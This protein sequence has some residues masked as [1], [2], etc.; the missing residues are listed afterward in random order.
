MFF[1]IVY[2]VLISFVCATDKK[3]NFLPCAIC[4]THPKC[5]SLLTDMGHYVPHCACMCVSVF[6]DT[7]IMLNNV[8]KF[9]FKP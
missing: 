6:C 5:V 1:N 9:G 7:H 4:I 3:Y 8:K 2:G